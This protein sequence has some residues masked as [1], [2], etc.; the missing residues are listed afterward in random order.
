[1]PLLSEW[2]SVTPLFMDYTN[3]GLIV[4]TVT[5]LNSKGIQS[6]YLKWLF[7]DT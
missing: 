4:I 2:K 3:E 5:K 7:A 6:A 1:M